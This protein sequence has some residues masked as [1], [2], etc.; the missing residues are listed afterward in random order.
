M[1]A[2][3]VACAVL[4]AM[5]PTAVAQSPAETV[6]VEDKPAAAAKP[7]LAALAKQRITEVFTGEEFKHTGKST[8]IRPRKRDATQKSPEWVTALLDTI[9][10]AAKFLAGLGEVVLWALVLALIVLIIVLRGRWLP[11]FGRGRRSRQ[12]RQGASNVDQALPEVSLPEDIPGTASARWREG[13]HAEALSVLYRG[14]LQVVAERLHVP[15]TAGATEEE[16]LRA[17]TAG[18]PNL[19]DYFKQLTA[20]WVGLAYAGRDP[21][22]IET[23]VAGYRRHLEATP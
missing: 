16:A 1:L 21:P 12:G 20:A 7:P 10:K 3:I 2:R 15:L 8:G 18:Q 13:R 22:E 6:P 17:V 14:A 4:I 11:Y 23:L 19:H 9:V 5:L